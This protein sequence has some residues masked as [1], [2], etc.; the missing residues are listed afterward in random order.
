MRVRSP[1]PAVRF[2]SKIWFNG[3]RRSSGS[4]S[5]NRQFVQMLYGKPKNRAVG[6]ARKPELWLFRCQEGA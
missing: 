6:F 3:S 1:P 5:L 4:K 2:S